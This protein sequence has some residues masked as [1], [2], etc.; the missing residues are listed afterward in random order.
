M[1]LLTLLIPYIFLMLVL[2]EVIILIAN[3]MKK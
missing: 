2:K 3:K 1:S